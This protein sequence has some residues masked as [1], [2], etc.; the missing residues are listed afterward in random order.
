MTEPISLPEGLGTCHHELEMSVLIGEPLAR[1]SIDQ[2]R[3]AV[4]GL[5]LGL[6]LTLRDLQSELKEKGQPWERAKAFDG[7]CPL[8]NFVDPEGVDLQNLDLILIANEEPRQ[9]GN[10]CA[11]L[12][13]VADLLVEISRSFRLLPGDVVLTGTPAGVGALRSGDLLH[14]ELGDLLR[15]ETRVI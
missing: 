3:A 7:A 15:V 10:T 9:A 6:D 8:S 13:S 5:G 14:A 2:A 12:F 4:V 11:M 1:A